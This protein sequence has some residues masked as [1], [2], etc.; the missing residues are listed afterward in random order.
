MCVSDFSNVISKS[1][2]KALA[3]A[4]EQEVVAEV[5]VSLMC[6]QCEVSSDLCHMTHVINTTSEA[7]P[8]TLRQQRTKPK[9]MAESGR[10]QR[11]KCTVLYVTL[12]LT[13]TLTPT[14]ALCVLQEF[15][16]DFVAVNPHLF[17]LNLPAVSRVSL[18]HRFPSSFGA[19]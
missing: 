11:P 5:Q 3:E 19:S 13:P 14:L 15:Y 2:I 9:K 10:R 18:L 4:D 12:T 1:E 7:A 6:D 16:G 8:P 17:S